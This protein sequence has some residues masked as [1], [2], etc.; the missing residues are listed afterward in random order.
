[1]W[2]LLLQL[3]VDIWVM[4]VP[5]KDNIADLPSRSEFAWS[6]VN[7]H[8]LCCTP[9]CRE[10]YGLLDYKMRARRVPGIYEPIFLKPSSWKSLSLASLEWR[11]VAKRR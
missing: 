1:M 9:N 6:S 7:V 2:K 10:Q 8:V 4:R 3:D 11:Q 5:S